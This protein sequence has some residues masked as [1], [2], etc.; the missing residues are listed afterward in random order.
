MYD[1]PIID[2]DLHHRW[3]DDAE[4]LKYLTARWRELVDPSRNTVPTE[5]PSGLF[6]HTTGSN[7]RAD[8]VPPTGGPPGSHYET[9]CEQWLDPFNVEKAVLSFD[10]GTSAGIPN[11]QLAS[12]LT[13]AASA[14]RPL[15]NK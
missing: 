5:V 7:K 8:A 10:I 9:L 12:A 4:L 13:R 15:R 14:V 11:P 6:V 1:G 3:H 2:I